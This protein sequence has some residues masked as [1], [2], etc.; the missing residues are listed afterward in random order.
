MLKALKCSAT[1]EACAYVYRYSLTPRIFFWYSSAVCFGN[2]AVN[3]G[4]I[5]ATFFSN[6]SWRY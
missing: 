3:F 5:F 1:T 4:E 2:N 6:S